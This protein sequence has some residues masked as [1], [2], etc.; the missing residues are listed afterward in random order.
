[1]IWLSISVIHMQVT[2][3]INLIVQQKRK[4][5]T[6]IA[7]KSNNK[8][9]IQ[10]FLLFVHMLYCCITVAGKGRVANMVWLSRHNVF[11]PAPCQ[12]SATQ[13]SVVS[14]YYRCISFIVNFFTQIRH[15]VFSVEFLTFFISRPF[16]TD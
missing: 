13:L 14:V 9:H 4:Q 1:M 16:I 15:L 3:Y 2:V 10:F 11:M 5:I 6:K 8:P 12:K 7:R